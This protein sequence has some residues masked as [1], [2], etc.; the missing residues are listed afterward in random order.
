MLEVCKN[1]PGDIPMPS[2]NE[3]LIL[4]QNPAYA[5]RTHETP[6]TRATIM[7]RLIFYIAIAA[8]AYYLYRSL[9]GR[10]ASQPPQIKSHETVRCDYCG[11]HLSAEDAVSDS[12]HHY[13][14]D[15]HRRLALHP[16]D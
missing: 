4:V 10:K 8:I 12:T 9:R 2:H 16:R 5:S 6:N 13:C 15:E 14:S 7:S 3:T 11:V 1:R